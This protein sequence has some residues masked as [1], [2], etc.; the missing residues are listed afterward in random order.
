MT[1]GT[2]TPKVS[3]N[4]ASGNLLRQILIIDGV[5][6]I[7][8]TAITLANIGVV[9]TVFGY[10][11]AKAKGYTEAVEPFLHQQIK[12]FYDEL[13]GNQELWI[14]GVEDTMTLTDMVTSTNAN[15]LK[16]LLTAAQGRITL[17]YI[18]RKPAGTYTMVAGHFLDKDVEDALL[19]SK[20][21]CLYQQS[22]NRP[23]RLLIEGRIN[24]ITQT[25][26]QPK[27]AN[28]TYAGVVLGSSL[29][30]GSASGAIAL[31]RAVKYASHIKLG[32]GQNGPLTV[33][34]IY[35]GNKTLEE[36]YPEQLDILSDAGFIIMHHREGSAGY[37]F[38]VDNMAGADDFKILVHGRL[39]DKAQRIATATTNPFLE[40]SIRINPDGTVNETDTKYLEDLIKTQIKAK[41]DG[42]IS[43]V[44]VIIPTN[45]DLINTSTL[46]IQVKIQPLGYLTW[47]FIIMG[48][49]KNI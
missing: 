14:M 30:N 3:V 21:L 16:K 39:I 33:A 24:D 42:Q 46:N 35:I 25:P 17:T 44:D 41:M 49:T 22:I 45:Q 23:V 20:A 5:A 19:A 37:Y 4:V 27:T 43:D 18:C 31:A 1:Q 36:F 26:Y 34:Q 9:K 48:L 2:G 47:I 28:N 8:G 6:G 15:G 7:V 13:G 10:E 12:E 38:G 11:D 32:N 40:T 29:N